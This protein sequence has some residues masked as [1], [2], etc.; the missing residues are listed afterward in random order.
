MPGKVCIC[1]KPDVNRDEQY[2]FYYLFVS[3]LF[4]SFLCVFICDPIF[5]FLFSSSL[6]NFVLY[7]L[8]DSKFQFYNSHSSLIWDFLLYSFPYLIILSR[9]SS[10]IILFLLFDYLH[11]YSSSR[12]TFQI[13]HSLFFLI[14]NYPFPT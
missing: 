11:F 2:Y 9:T 14:S 5:E 13:L 3:G 4:I 12:H 6:S 7:F 8:L 10:V 1:C